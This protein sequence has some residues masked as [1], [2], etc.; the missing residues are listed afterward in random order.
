MLSCFFFSSVCD[1]QWNGMTALHFAARD[2]SREAIETLLAAQADPSAQDDVCDPSLS[3]FLCLFRRSSL[4]QKRFRS[5]CIH[6]NAA[7]LCFVHFYFGSVDSLSCFRSEVFPSIHPSSRF[8]ISTPVPWLPAFPL[9]WTHA[10]RFSSS[11]PLRGGDP[12]GL[13]DASPPRGPIPASWEI[14]KPLGCEQQS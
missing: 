6:W 2:G 9:F 7:M 13:A 1:G 11:C 3:S 10:V 5:A 4:H 12:S 14:E 8:L